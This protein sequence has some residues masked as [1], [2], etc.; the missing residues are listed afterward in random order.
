MHLGDRWI[1]TKTDSRYK[2]SEQIVVQIIST[3]IIKWKTYYVFNRL[4]FIPRLENANNVLVRYDPDTKRLLYL[5]EGK[6]LPL[7]PVGPGLD[8]K[9][10]ASVD[11]KGKRV[12]NRLSYMTCVDCEDKGM[13]MVFDQGIGV[14][15]NPDH[16]RV[17]DGKL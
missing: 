1:Y 8:A 2:K 15:A 5:V 14:T 4:P 13:E 11:E 10:D 7:L 9:F 16:P 17:G 3:S 6:E 12:F